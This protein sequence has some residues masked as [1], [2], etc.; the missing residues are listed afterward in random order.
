MALFII[1]RTTI[2]AEDVP[3]KENIH[4]WNASPTFD[5][6]ARQLFAEAPNVL[7]WA[8]DQDLKLE[9]EY[10]YSHMHH[11]YDVVVYARVT[12]NYHRMVLEL[13]KPDPVKVNG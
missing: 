4:P 2:A 8:K 12:D 7:M 6:T 9:V 13:S 10:Q 11:H 5:Q 1:H 3:L